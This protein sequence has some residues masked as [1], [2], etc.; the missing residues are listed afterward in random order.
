VRKELREIGP[1]ESALRPGVVVLA[2]QSEGKLRCR[3]AI[4]ER[5]V[6]DERV[7]QVNFGLLW[8]GSFIEW[9]G[10]QNRCIDWQRGRRAE[11]RHP[12]PRASLQLRITEP[13]SGLGGGLSR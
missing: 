10:L 6:A 3:L 4:Y 7:D 13:R 5:P 1:G 12:S 2:G 11:E 9:W 8:I